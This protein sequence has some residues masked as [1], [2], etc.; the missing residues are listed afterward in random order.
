MKNGYWS[1]RTFANAHAVVGEGVGALKTIDFIIFSI[2]FIG[3]S[4][5]FSSVY[6]IFH[7]KDGA[8]LIWNGKRRS[9][10]SLPPARFV[11]LN[12]SLGTFLDRKA[13]LKLLDAPLA[14][15]W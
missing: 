8:D 5:L 3:I 4:I 6:T 13:C 2:L 7:K 10:F 1:G 11:F 12:K 15:P 9:F 14:S